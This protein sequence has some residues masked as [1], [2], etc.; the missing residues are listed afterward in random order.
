MSTVAPNVSAIVGTRVAAKLIAAAG[1]IK[2]LQMIP[3]G[4][5]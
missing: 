1:G 4:N 2:E 3:A 5:I